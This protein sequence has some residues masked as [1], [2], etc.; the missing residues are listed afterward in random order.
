MKENTPLAEVAA[1]LPQEAAQLLMLCSDSVQTEVLRQMRS[2][3]VYLEE[4]DCLF[5]PVS[6]EFIL[7]AVVASI[8]PLYGEIFAVHMELASAESRLMDAEALVA[9]LSKT[10]T[11]MIGGI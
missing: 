2:V 3:I 4:S 5:E 7:N 6:Y 11:S 8:A 10:I 9:S 1:H